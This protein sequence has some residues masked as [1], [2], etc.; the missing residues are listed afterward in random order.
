MRH[1]R[2]SLAVVVDE[3]GGTAGVVTLEDMVEEIIGEIRDEHDPDFEAVRP[4]PD[5][6]TLLAGMT[7]LDEVNDRLQL[8]LEDDEHNTLAGYLISRL[9]RLGQVGDEVRV[10]AGRFEVLAVKGR[11]I[12]SIRYTPASRPGSKVA[13]AGHQ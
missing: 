6:T 8:G 2:L 9:G 1:D 11:T 13:T 10:P 4:Q 5:G 12:A 3:Y 7:S